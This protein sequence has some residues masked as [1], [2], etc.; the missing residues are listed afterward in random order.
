MGLML[1]ASGFVKSSTGSVGE[2]ASAKLMIVGIISVVVGVL[3]LI[4]LIGATKFKVTRQTSLVVNK[5]IERLRNGGKMADVD[6]TTEATLN[7]LTG[8]NYHD[9]KV[10]QK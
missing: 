4:A 8:V 10:W 6:P 1:D 3:I 5:E 9:I 2:P 7:D